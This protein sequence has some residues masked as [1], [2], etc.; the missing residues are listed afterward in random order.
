MFETADAESHVGGAID[1]AAVQ[2]T[3][4]RELRL[5]HVPVALR[6]FFDAQGLAR[7]KDACPY[8]EPVRPLSFC[9]AELGA[10]MEGLTVLVEPQ[11]LW[12][13]SARMAFG[14]K[15][16]DEGDIRIHRKFCVDDAQAARFL[17]SKPRLPSGS[18]LALAVSP[19][20][21]AGERPDLVRFCCDNMQAYHLLDDWMAVRDVHPLRP[22]LCL[23]SSVCGGSVFSFMEKQA[24]LTLACAGS[25]SSGKMERGEINVT[26]PGMDI[27]AVAARMTERRRKT[28]GVSLVHGGN[29]FPGADICQNC[30]LIMFRRVENVGAESSSGAK[31]S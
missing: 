15:E 1:Y 19:L 31:R 23:N 24:N 12:C 30:P 10:R 28:G 18:L 4:M 14:W 21:G 11:K 22:A 25:Y 5:M 7:F 3:L 27:A 29:P 17:A 2:E 16:Q 8:H 26:M 13:R 9:Q 20:A 6:F